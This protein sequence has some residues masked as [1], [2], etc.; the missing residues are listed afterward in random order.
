LSV[1]RYGPLGYAAGLGSGDR[2]EG[3]LVTKGLELAKV[4]THL[5]VEVDS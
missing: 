1:E 4:A 3:D 2:F 5:A